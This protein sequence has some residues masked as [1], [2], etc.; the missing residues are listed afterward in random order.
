MIKK[1]TYNKGSL[2]FILYPTQDKTFI[3][4]CE[5]LCLIVEEKD[6]E[7]AHLKI[8]A[9]ALS[10]IKNVCENKLGEHLLNQTLPDEIK[11]EFSNY[12]KKKESEN[13]EKKRISFEELS[14]MVESTGSFTKWLE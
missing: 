10:Y 11:D 4:A 7:L 3:A 9:N 14:T 2:L 5:E 12:I 8:Q 1:N 13:F 6:A